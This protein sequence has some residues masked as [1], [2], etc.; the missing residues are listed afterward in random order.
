MC[1]QLASVALAMFIL[2][3]ELYK[4][5]TTNPQQRAIN[6]RRGPTVGNTTTGTKRA[7]FM[8]EKSRTG[9]ERSKLADM[10]MDAVAG[11]GRGQ[12]SHRDPS[13]EP[14]A[15]RVNVGRGPRR[16]N[17]ART[18]AA[19]RRGALGATSGY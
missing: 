2:H 3:Q 9:N 11:R 15:A 4:M 10:I 6:Q 16:G 1:Q 14:V 5:K 8:A 18:S 19:S 13:V 17:A 7:D 12:Q